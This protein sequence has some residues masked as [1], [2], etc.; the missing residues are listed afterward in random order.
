MGR[1][2]FDYARV[3]TVEQNLE[4]QLAELKKF[5]ADER[6]IYWEKISGK[7]FERPEYNRM[8]GNLREGDLVLVCSLDRL[9]RNYSEIRT[10]WQLITQTIR[11]DIKVLDMPLLDTRSCGDSLDGRFIA[12]LVLQTLSYTAE[13]ERENT[14]RRQRQGIDVMPIVNGKRTS[15]KTGRAIGRP[16]AT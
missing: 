5:I 10:Q 9:G 15:S 2:I 3:S 1:E 13:K 12:D 6:D 14:H 7:N 11:A 16:V 8:I 4:R